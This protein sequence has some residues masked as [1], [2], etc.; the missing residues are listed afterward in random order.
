MDTRTT[1]YLDETTLKKLKV[2]AAQN[3]RTIKDIISDALTMYLMEKEGRNDRT[4]D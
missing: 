4:E 1:I 3:D 2:F